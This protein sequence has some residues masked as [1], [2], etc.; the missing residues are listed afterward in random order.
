M[1]SLN[2]LRPWAKPNGRART[3]SSVLVI[4]LGR[5]GTALAQTLVSMDVEVMAVDTDQHLVDEW[6]AELTHVRQADSTSIE[7]LRQLGAE[8]FDAAVVAIGTD[9]EASI[10]TVAALADL[11]LENIWAKAIT[12]AHARILQRVGAHEVVFP[13]NE[14]GERVAHMVT[15][16]VADYIKIDDGFVMAELEVPSFLVGDLLGETDLRKHHAVTVVCVKPKGGSFTYA[17]ADTLLGSGDIL[18]VAGGT[19]DLER[20]VSRAA[21]SRE[22]D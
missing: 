18:V 3:A 2:R 6:A 15:G 13:E 21:K 1:S 19:A 5:F 16:E 20:F 7:T 9:L 8:N 22:E 14:M 11:G 12:N 10:L 17:T 4:G